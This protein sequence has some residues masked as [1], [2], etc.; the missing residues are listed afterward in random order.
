MKKHNHNQG[1]TIIEVVLVLAI[2]GLIFLMVFVAL[3]ALQRSQRDAQRKQDISLLVAAINNY[4]TNN[5]N[6]MPESIGGNDQYKA[7][8]DSSGGWAKEYGDDG[9]DITDYWK[10]SHL[11][12]DLHYRDWYLRRAG[13]VNLPEVYMR[14]DKYGFVYFL[15]DVLCHEETAGGWSVISS[16]GRSGTGRFAILYNQ[17]SKNV[18]GG[19]RSNSR[20]NTCVDSNGQ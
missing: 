17:E 10:P 4:K 13:E 14:N 9:L 18:A 20:F 12:T 19:N 7:K 2:A 6:R 5:K 15:T 11:I 16:D 8:I 3:P 1:F